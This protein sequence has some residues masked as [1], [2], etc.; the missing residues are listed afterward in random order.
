MP[1]WKSF[2][3]D[4]LEELELGEF[5]FR[6][7]LLPYWHAKEIPFKQGD[8]DLIVYDFDGVMTDNNDV[9]GDVLYRKP[10]EP[11]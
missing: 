10:N 6:K 4:T 11:T 9:A 3:I 7:H 5:Y 2:E 8:I 1:F